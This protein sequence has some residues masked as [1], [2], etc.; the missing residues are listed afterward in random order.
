MVA[1]GSRWLNK[2]LSEKTLEELIAKIA[3]QENAYFYFIG[4]SPAEKIIADRPHSLFPRSQSVGGLTFSLWQA[5]M[6][7]MDLVIAVDSAALALCGMTK[8]ASL[9]FFGPSLASVYKPLGDHHVAWQGACP[10]GQKFT[11]RC[12]LLRTCKTGACLK[13]ASSDELLQNVIQLSKRQSL[14]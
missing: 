10:Y 7:K 1:C 2:K 4:G 14:N 9:S 11:T 13:S 5:L 3:H 8:T 12:P 6:R